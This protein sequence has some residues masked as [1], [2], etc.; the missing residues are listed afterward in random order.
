MTDCGSLSSKFDGLCAASRSKVLCVLNPRSR[1][2]SLLDVLLEENRRAK[3]SRFKSIATSGRSQINLERRPLLPT[4]K[5]RACR[6]EELP[7]GPL[8]Y[9]RDAP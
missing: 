2:I 9:V 3:L 8:A 6:L 1:W 7:G 4:P 5:L